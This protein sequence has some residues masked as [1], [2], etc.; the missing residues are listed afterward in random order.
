MDNVKSIIKSI[1]FNKFFII[2][3]I[4]VVILLILAASIYLL[5]IDDGEIDDDTK[6]KPSNYTQNVKANGSSGLTVDKDAIVNS[7]LKD[8]NYSDDEIAKMS[9]EE[10]IKKLNINTKLKKNPSVTSLDEVTQAEL[11]WCANDTY[12][13]YLETPEQLEKLL[14]AEIITQYPDMGQADAKLNGIIKFERRK[15]DGSSAFLTYLDSSTFSSYVSSNDTKVLEYFTLDEQGNALIAYTNTTTETLVF[16]DNEVN[17]SEYTSNLNDSNKESD[18]VYSKVTPSVST[19]KINYKSVVEKYTMPFKYLWSLLVVGEDVNFVLELA[20]LVQNSQ[21][22]ISIYDNIT[23][24]EDVNTYTYKKETRI[25]KYARLSVADSY[26]VTGFSTERYW[27]SSDS[28][29]AEGNYDSNYEATYNKDETEYTVTHTIINQKNDVK[30]DLTKAD[31]WI[32]EY[33]KEYAFPDSLIPIVSNN[34]VTLDNTEFVL[35][36]TTSKNSNND[37]SL[38]N[39][40][41]AVDFA[42][43]VKEYIEQNA[44]VIS[45]TNLAYNNAFSGDANVTKNR[46]TSTE[47]VDTTVDD[48][49]EVIEADVKVS[50]VELKNYDRKIERN[51]SQTTTITEQKYV[52]QTPINNIKDDKNAERDNFVKILCK[53]THETAK[54]YLTD[55]TTTDWLWEIMETNAPDMIDLTK[56]LFYKA[57]DRS[58]SGITSY[59]FSEY[60]KNDFSVV[61]STGGSLSLITPTLTKENFV[62][63][64]NAYSNK[65]SGNKKSNF[66]ANFLPYAGDIYDWSVKYGVN[67][68]LVVITASTE[69]KFK[70]GGGNYN[71]WGLGVYNGSSTGASFSSFED[72]IKAYAELIKGYQTGDKAAS[73]NAIAAERQAAGVDPTGYGA[74]D[75]FSGMQSL[76]SFL[77]SHVEGSSGTGGYYYMDPDRAGVTKIYKTHEEF[78]A[79]CKDSGKAEHASGTE[80]TVWEQGQYTAWQVEQKLEEWNSIFGDYGSLSGGNSEIV[81]IAKSKLGCPYVWGSKGPDSFDCSGLVYWTYSQKGIIVPTSTSEYKVYAG[82]SNEIDWSQAQP[83][84]ILLV[85]DYERDIGVGHAAIYLGDDE[86][87]H[88]P[89]TGDVVKISKGASKTF[90]HVFR[91]Q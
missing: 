4:M 21:I 40:T 65:I 90:K 70:S 30:Y 54:D 20:D 87:I 61:G 10:I 59:D 64:M 1:L 15:S 49:E 63:A 34:S 91:F 3:I 14:N 46:T 47:N 79:L 88:A 42:K 36:N 89:Q 73:I 60:S 62:S 33:G 37:G 38:L 72:G 12:S 78:L 68:E 71:Y 51:H 8:L 19:I 31:V 84:D 24:T 58:F 80:T 75:T 41:E 82:T 66:D 17:I 9:D 2:G 76:Y 5:V 48:S 27:L 53:D 23:T 85:F 56:Y 81:E 22:T 7:S 52:A 67:P 39:D 86:Y 35:N 11:L 74:S 18:G 6:G 44:K 29:N 16:N 45:E 13:E 77:G 83:G 28:P 57:T 55:G 43:S 25:D 50:Y 69:Q 26:G 32:V